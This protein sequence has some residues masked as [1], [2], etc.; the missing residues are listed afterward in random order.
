M[1]VLGIW[2]GCRVSALLG[3][4]LVCLWLSHPHR[5]VT[6]SMHLTSE[7][8]PCC[9]HPSSLWLR[10]EG[11][12][13]NSSRPPQGGQ[14]ES[15]PQCLCPSQ[16]TSQLVLNMAVARMCWE[17]FKNPIIQLLEDPGFGSGS[18]RPEYHKP[19][20]GHHMCLA[21]PPFHSTPFPWTLKWKFQSSF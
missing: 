8:L 1:E 6:L 3:E 13:H 14:W 12:E 7:Q 5:H 9:F 2:V 20:D 21:G 4:W 16:G 11:P 18:H 15:R 10:Q 17:F 19:T